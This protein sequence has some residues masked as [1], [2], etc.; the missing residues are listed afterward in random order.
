MQSNNKNILFLGPY[1]QND[2]WGLAARDYVRSLLTTGHNIHC[3]P[4]YMSNNI[5]PAQE[6]ESDI[7][8]SENN[9]L[10]TYDIVIQ[11]V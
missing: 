4:V 6:I 5:S 8:A 10:Q 1:R 11:N 7:L 9:T 3:Q 2:G